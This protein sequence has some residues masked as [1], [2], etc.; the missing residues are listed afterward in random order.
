MRLEKIPVRAA[1]RRAER[2]RLPQGPSVGLIPA[3]RMLQEL[4]PPESKV[5]VQFGARRRTL[6]DILVRYEGRSTRT[7]A[8]LL[9]VPRLRTGSPRGG[10]TFHFR[11]GRWQVARGA[12]RL[13][14]ARE[15]ERER[16]AHLRRGTPSWRASRQWRLTAH[17]IPGKSRWPSTT[18]RSPRWRSWEPLFPGMYIQVDFGR[19]EKADRVVVDTTPD[20]RQV[21]LRLEGQTRSD[22]PWERLAESPAETRLPTPPNLRH[23]ATSE[24]K[25]RGLN[26]CSPSPSDFWD[27]GYPQ[28]TP[29]IGD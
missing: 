28:Q 3:S 26:T 11:R 14:L 6:P 10:L 15:L 8:I 29:E 21:R 25:C 7:S 12:E 23:L 1:L 19:L 27:K 2:E 16:V 18:T 5:P 20:Q 4:L 13:G 17:P 24:I 22:A 9:S